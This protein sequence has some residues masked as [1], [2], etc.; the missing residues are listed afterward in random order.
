MCL[1][2]ASFKLRALCLPFATALDYLLMSL[3]E[4]ISALHASHQDSH[5]LTSNTQHTTQIQEDASGSVNLVSDDEDESGGR[6]GTRKRAA[7]DNGGDE[8]RKKARQ[9]GRQ[10]EDEDVIVMVD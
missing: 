3:V 2:R 9:G 8:G 1:K 4:Q 7:V 10:A 6:G 5:T